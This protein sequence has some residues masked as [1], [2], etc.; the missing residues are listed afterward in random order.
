MKKIFILLLMIFALT[1]CDVMNVEEDGKLYLTNSVYYNG[2][3]IDLDIYVDDVKVGTI[4]YGDTKT[5]TIKDEDKHIL[6]A[7]SCSWEN[8]GYYTAVY[9]TVHKDTEIKAYFSTTGIHQTN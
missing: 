6:S 4:Y 3:S 2:Q 7:Y 9:F 5:F 1:S 8:Y